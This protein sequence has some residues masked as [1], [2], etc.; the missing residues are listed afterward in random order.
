MYVYGTPILEEPAIVLFML[1][2]MLVLFVGLMNLV[3]GVIVQRALQMAEV[4]REA[5]LFH[6]QKKR[7]E[8]IPRLRD[9]FASIDADGSG[10]LDLD[11]IIGAPPEV[12]QALMELVKSDDVA[13]LFNTIDQDGSGEIELEEFI[14]GLMK[15]VEGGQNAMEFLRTEKMLRA[16]ADR[17][18][19]LVHAVTGFRLG[20]GGDDEEEEEEEEE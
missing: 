9:L 7:A 5:E 14:Q 2:V 6:A 17:M 18:V 8:T 3:T 11:E 1:P 15:I 10:S 12:Q 16:Q 13:E 20:G 19:E 4:D